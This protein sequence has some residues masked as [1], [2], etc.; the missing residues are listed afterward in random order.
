LSGEKHIV[1]FTATLNRTGSEIVLLE[2]LMNAK[3]DHKI[4]VIAKFKGNMFDE[5]PE[6][7]EK[8]SLYGKQ[9]G[10]LG[11]SIY[12]KL[13][14]LFVIDGIL[15]KYPNAT[16]YINTVVLPDI[17]EYAESH[18]VKAIVHSHEL[19]Q[20]YTGLNKEQIERIVNYPE[21]IIANSNA[22][23]NVA[24][25]YGRKNAIEVVNP[26]L[27]TRLVQKT[28]FENIR[29]KL[30][31]SEK[32]FVWVMCGTLDKN[33]DPFLFIGIAKELKMLWP[34]FKM[35][36]IGGKADNS[37]IDKQCQDLVKKHGLEKEVI[38][39]GDVKEKFYDYFAMAN[40]FVLT[41]QFE[42]FSM[43]T[44]EALYLQLPI[45][46]NDCV[47]VREVLGTNLGCI[48]EKGSTPLEFANEMMNVMKAPNKIDRKALRDRA[49]E[50]G[51]EHIAKKWNDLLNKVI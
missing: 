35:L 26:A 14:K 45:V 21:L 42:S 40:G 16:W 29:V 22:S 18:K 33:K 23:A 46:A 44:L 37:D 1:F 17:L 31:I 13:R 51:I 3:L 49:L 38:F 47:G 12:N 30:G 2:L 36:W 27:S 7:I 20:M 41:S 8:F 39:A 24:K 32:T 11:N 9:F 34:E 43:A 50:F 5:I 4:T 10:G 28:K 48:V 25:E 15:K 6:G 19:Q